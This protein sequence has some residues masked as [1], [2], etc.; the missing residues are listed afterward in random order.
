MTGRS[1]FRLQFVLLLACVVCS[2]SLSGCESK[3][4]ANP[5]TEAPPPEVGIQVIQSQNVPIISELPG[6]TS[7]Y[8]VAEVRPQV[9]GILQKRLFREGADVKANEVLYQIDPAMYQASYASA[10]AA[11]GKAEASRDT[12]RIRVNRYKEL[13]KIKAVSD[14]DYDNAAGSLR[15]AEAEVEAAKAAL[16]TARIN[17]AYTRVESPITG[18]IGKSA[19]TVG[20]LVTASQANALATVQQL[21]P[22]YVDVVQ[23]NAELLRLKRM[24]SNGDA[25]ADNVVKQAKVNLLLEDGTPYPLEGTLEFSDVTVDQSTGSI[26]LR[27]IFPNP[28]TTLLP[29]MYVRAQIQEGV[30]KGAVLAPQQGVTRDTRGNPTALVV[31]ASDTVEQRNLKVDRAVGDQWL[32]SEGLNPGDRIIVEGVQKV[33]PGIPV[34]VVQAGTPSDGAAAQPATRVQ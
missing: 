6:R 1:R 26:T 28:K 25:T 2:L 27:A 13:V 31:G 15:E 17:V 3:T 9:G 19:V 10:K 33:R 24:L 16:E 7:A 23:S 14:Q 21:D 30:R 11:L 12:L 34:R 20:A 5:R 29:G 22:I 8:L 18:R 32:V 4:S